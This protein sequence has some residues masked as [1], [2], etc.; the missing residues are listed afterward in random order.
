MILENVLTLFLKSTRKTRNKKDYRLFV[1]L[2]CILVKNGKNCLHKKL[3]KLIRYSGVKHVS[4][5]T[6]RT[7]LS[8]RA[9]GNIDAPCCKVINIL[10]LVG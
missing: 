2:Y 5:S 9:G 8:K 6:V 1:L 4:F 3:F 10:C 7:R